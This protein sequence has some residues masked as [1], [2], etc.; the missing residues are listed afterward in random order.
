MYGSMQSAFGNCLRNYVGENDPS[1][2]G[3]KKE[4]IF[5][6]LCNNLRIKDKH[7]VMTNEIKV[8]SS[9]QMD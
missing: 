1:Y 8:K 7:V 9:K 2:S 3:N 4:Q 6:I 5:E